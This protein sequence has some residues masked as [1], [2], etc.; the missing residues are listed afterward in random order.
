M[1]E[2]AKKFATR[3]LVSHILLL[4]IVVATVFVA[5]RSVYESA[6]EQALSQAVGRQEVLAR[7]T[8]RGIESF[9]DS[10]LGDL[11]LIRRAEEHAV[12]FIPSTTIIS[13]TCS[14]RGCSPP[15]ACGCHRT[16]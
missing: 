9:Y 8:A 6:R 16:R 11:D 12:G 7:Q 5:A 10:I 14:R 2:A 4:S 3:T 13:C 1:Q 15:G